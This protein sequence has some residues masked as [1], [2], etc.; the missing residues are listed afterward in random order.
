MT[1]LTSKWTVAKWAAGATALLGA[2]SCGGDPGIM[3]PP[4]AAAIATVDVTVSTDTLTALG[5]TAQFTATARDGDGNIIAGVTFAWTTSDANVATI[6]ADGLATAVANGEVTIT[7]TASKDNQTRSAS[8]L[9][10]V[11]Q[12]VST[13]TVTPANAT[14]AAGAT[15][16]YS[17]AATDANNN[18]VT[19]VNFLWVSSD[20]NVATVDQTGLADGVAGGTVTITAVGQGEPGST[21]LTVTGAPTGQAAQVVFTVQPSNATAGVAISAAIEVE[22]R[23][24]GGNVVTDARDAV[25]LGIATNPGGAAILGTATVNAING[26]ASF[27]GIAVDKVGT[28]YTLTATSGALSAATSTSFDISPGAPA[29]LAF[30]TQPSNAEGNV[31]FSPAVRV[32]ILDAFD[33]VVTG[34][35]N[36]VTVS[37]GTNPWASVSQLL[38]NPSGT[39]T[40]TPTNGMVTFSD[41]S[42]GSPGSGYTLQA[43]SGV[44]RGAN[45][46]IFDIT[47]TMQSVAVSELGSH[48][49]GIAAGGT[50]CWGRNSTGQLG[51][52]VTTPAELVPVLVRGGLAFVQVTGGSGFS[53]GLTAAGD[54]YCWGDNSF[55]QLGDGNRPFNTQAPVAV[56]GGLTFASIDAGLQH[57]CGVLTT[58]TAGNA[59]CWG[60]DFDGRL[61][62]DV[63]IADQ[64]TPAQVA[65]G[66]TFVSV[67]A[68]N[69]HS[70]GVDVSGDAYCWG[71]DFGGKLGDDVTILAQ[72]TPVIVAGALTFSSVSAGFDHTCGVTA[73]PTAYCWGD[74]NQGELGDDI[75]LADQ[76]T[77]V[78]VFG[79]LPWATVDAGTNS[80]C[81]ITTADVAYCWGS[82]S[83][84]QLGDGNAPTN[85]PTRSLVAGGLAF[86]SIGV[87]GIHACGFVASTNEVYCWGDGAEGEMGDGTQVGKSTPVRIIQ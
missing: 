4:A 5:A 18:A 30:A 40:A 61:G 66:I 64:S 35:T 10:A 76:S 38:G 49:C 23:D 17:A 21:S 80:T 16:Q 48:A 57:A 56:S 31:P 26:V 45:S 3:D 82:N 19:G 65:G 75:T 86:T 54:A 85:S 25:S 2:L 50:Y 72:P 12:Q 71:D 58:A 70:C 11:A 73:G 62:D 20:H 51:A 78:Q 1:M 32:S 9:L 46:T 53:C 7:V 59:Y 81:G 27:S 63:T 87:S 41:I 33:N 44:L 28:G 83:G 67:S 74:D 47:L 14:V 69:R 13:V 68:G 77:P 43:V 36:A 29:S 79:G 15:L 6:G 39:L 84:G 55:G 22:L 24:A 42:V 52:G 8:A 37:I 60:R 34:A